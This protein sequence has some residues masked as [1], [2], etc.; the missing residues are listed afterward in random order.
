[1]KALLATLIIIVLIAAACAQNNNGGGN[2]GGPLA[3]NIIVDC[4]QIEATELAQAS[5]LAGGGPRDGGWYIP[6]N[7]TG[8]TSAQWRAA[9]TT[10]GP[11]VISEDNP[12]SV[13]AVSLVSAILGHLPTASF[14]YVEQTATSLDTTLTD[15]QLVTAADYDVT[16][17]GEFYG[18]LGSRIIVL[19]R[20]YATS[21][22]RHG[23]T[24][25]ALADANVYGVALEFNPDLAGYPALNI[26]G[27][28]SACLAAGKHCYL[29]MPPNATPADTYLAAMQS[30]T[31]YLGPTLLNSPLVNL[32]PAVYVRQS[33]GVTFIG[34]GNN[35]IQSAVSYLKSYRSAQ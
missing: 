24:N 30:I 32:V 16:Y 15:T 35:T 34:T 10:L 23:W 28:V 29:L 11:T 3:F 33:T 7:S 17:D 4:N 19:T 14:Q 20:S 9:M 5:L 31:A 25:T 13:A 21:D 22:P 1:M 8:I 27:F 6:G 2:N 26:A 12:S 18:T